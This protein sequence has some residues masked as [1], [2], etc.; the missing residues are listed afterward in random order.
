MP[1]EKSLF[2]LIIPRPPNEG[3]VP[4]ERRD[5][6]QD[7]PKQDDAKPIGIKI[8]DAML[9]PP[10]DDGVYY[11]NSTY[12]QLPAHGPFET[13]MFIDN[14]DTAKLHQG[15]DRQTTTIMNN[16]RSIYALNNRANFLT[17]S[18]GTDITYFL[19]TTNNELLA[20]G[21]NDSGQVGDD[22]GIEQSKPVLIMKDVANLYFKRV[23]NSGGLQD[24]YAIYALKTD[25]SRWGWGKGIKNDS[26][27]IAFAPEQSEYDRWERIKN[28]SQQIAYAPVQTDN[29]YNANQELLTDHIF[30]KNGNPEVFTSILLPRNIET[31]LGGRDNIT[32][33][34]EIESFERG[35]GMLPPPPGA[36]PKKIPE[37]SR[38]YAITKD[39]TLWGWGY[40]EGTLG[41]GTRATRTEPVKI[42]E[43]V[44]RL[45][46][47]YFITQTNDWYHYSDHRDTNSNVR[48]SEAKFT[49]QLALENVFYAY[50]LGGVSSTG[51]WYTPDGKLYR[52]TFDTI[53]EF[54]VREN[55]CNIK[56][57]SIVRVVDGQIITPKPQIIPRRPPWGNVDLIA[58]VKEANFFDGLS[59]KLQNKWENKARIKHW[60]LVE[61]FNSVPQLLSEQQWAT[62]TH[63]D[64]KTVTLSFNVIN[65][66]GK[67]RE[68]I[69]SFVPD[70]NPEAIKPISSATFSFYPGIS[71][72][73]KEVE[74]FFDAICKGLK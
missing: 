61:A 37:E 55:V 16:V 52:S 27:Q 24:G 48:N 44:K 7:D 19:I 12:V 47:N 29:N 67:Q 70:T 17:E 65:Q 59:A 68:M 4:P 57:P 22:T 49:P 11:F 15:N 26:Q 51:T 73:P 31:I 35:I 42:A 64:G 34:I 58:F 54:S 71:L 43:N 72:T 14:N 45:L 66:E 28:A 69:I 21:Q 39:G 18:S 30:E 10:G 3:G 1:I 56:F 38:F 25:K 60:T 5:A 36:K 9:T 20:W 53:K 74:D 32:T 62:R 13:F 63:R 46:P 40:N 8:D 41:E 33:S 6:K 50:T 23:F 2:T